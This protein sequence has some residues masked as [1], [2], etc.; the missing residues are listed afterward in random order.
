[1]YSGLKED[2]SCLHPNLFGST[3]TAFVS[4]L[5]RL[6]RILRINSLAEIG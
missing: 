3:E 1:M 4:Q 5:H 2:E 6:G